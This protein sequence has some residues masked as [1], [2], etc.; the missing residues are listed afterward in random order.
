[1]AGFRNSNDPRS[2]LIY[3]YVAVLKEVK[4]KVFVFENVQGLLSHNKGKTFKN[5]LQLFLEV[6]YVVEARL[7][8][9]SDYGVP[10]KKTGNYY[11]SEK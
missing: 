7:M 4:P 5:L 6:G 8:D 3:D 9:F 11:W 1:M 2:K 10:Q